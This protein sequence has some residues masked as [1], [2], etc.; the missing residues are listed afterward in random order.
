MI[1]SY[2]RMGNSW[3][4]FKSLLKKI[5]FEVLTTPDVTRK[6]ITL[7]VRNSPETVCFPF[8]VA[9]GS[10]IESLDLGADA[11]IMASTN[12]P[13]RF[14]E[15]HRIQE[16]ILRKMDY[17]FEMIVINQDHLLDLWSEQS[18]AKKLIGYNGATRGQFFRGVRLLY[19]K[20]E[21]LKKAE[22]MRNYSWAYEKEEGKSEKVFKDFL[23]ELDSTDKIKELKII[24]SKY[25][26]RFAGIERK[27]VQDKIKIALIGE[28]YVTAVPYVN[29]D[30]ERILGRMG[31]EVYNHSTLYDWIN[32]KRRLP[33]VGRINGEL[34]NKYLKYPIGGSEGIR[35]ITSIRKAS[36]E[37]YDAII[38]LYPFTCMP[39]VAIKAMIPRLSR[40][41]QIPILSLNLDE[42]TGRAGFITRIEAFIDM[43][44]RLK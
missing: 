2:P 27:Q 14:G 31:V 15:Y 33:L 42:Q 32:I 19:K 10:M 7:G 8:K 43:I 6:T 17:K 24:E 9:L 34:G 38:H 21:L 41:Y 40:D 25:G 3:I 36:K 16:S 23:G 12:G 5:G 29:I 37:G 20:A 18:P 39:E 35:T 22:S 1:V 4:A 26:K 11:I 44:R 13:C 30:I 28:I